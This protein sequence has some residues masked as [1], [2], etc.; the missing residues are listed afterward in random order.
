[1]KTFGSFIVSGTIGFIIHGIVFNIATLEL[2]NNLSYLMAFIISV[3]I[4]FIINKNLTFK[5]KGKNIS[6]I[7]SL[8][9]LGQTKGLLINYFTFYIIINYIIINTAIN[10]NIA[11]FCASLITL[12]FNYFYAKKITF[13]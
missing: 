7:Y 5:H 13:N 4:T 11:F 1:M 12:F 2:N 10:R 9:L 8:Y 3:N 6:K